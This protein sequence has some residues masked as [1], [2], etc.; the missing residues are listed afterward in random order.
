MNNKI[1]NKGRKLNRKEKKRQRKKRFIKTKEEKK[2]G[3]FQDKSTHR[4]R[5]WK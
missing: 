3:N 4:K 1:G 5:K 2:K